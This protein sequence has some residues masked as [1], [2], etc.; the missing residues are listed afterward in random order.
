MI[1]SIVLSD[2]LSF[3]GS[4][5]NFVVTFCILIGRVTHNTGRGVCLAQKNPTDLELKIISQRILT[6]RLSDLMNPATI[7]P[8]NLKE[9]EFQPPLLRVFIRTPNAPDA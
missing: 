1:E 5:R 7:S 4:G 3:S 9:N 8:S 2:S 6:Q